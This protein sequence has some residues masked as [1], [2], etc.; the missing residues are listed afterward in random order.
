M[1]L[2]VKFQL[3]EDERRLGDKRPPL[4]ETAL[5]TS[6]GHS[7]QSSNEH[8]VWGVWAVCCK[9]HMEQ[10]CVC[11]G[12]KVCVS[13]SVST[14]VSCVCI[15][16]VFSVGVCVCGVYVCVCV[17]V[18]VHVCDKCVCVCVCAYVC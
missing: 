16:A 8:L 17:C 13:V 7:A 4:G 18:C 6:P 15:F 11:V 5:T 10:G 1:R 9:P 2:I 14:N 12:R 3:S